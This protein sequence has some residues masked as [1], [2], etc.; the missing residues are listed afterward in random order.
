[1]LAQ[2]TSGM[3][4]VLIRLDWLQIQYLLREE[5]LKDVV[6]TFGYEV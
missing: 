6:V 5:A 2:I 3:Y 1:M 4:F